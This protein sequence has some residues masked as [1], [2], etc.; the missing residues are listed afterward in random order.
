MGWTESGIYTATLRDMLSNIIAGDVRLVTS[1]LALHNNTDTPDFTLDPATWTNAYE[2][3]DA[4]NWTTGGRLVSAAASG[5]GS[6]APTMAQSSDKKSVV[7]DA[8]DVSVASTTIAAARGLKWQMDALSPKAI[9]CG[10]NFGADYT[11]SAGTF[12]IT[13]SNSPAG[14][15][16]I[17][18][19]PS[20]A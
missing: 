3:T 5:G 7:F 18:C 19:V 17:K 20:G 1:K 6:I 2:V 4:S 10:I 11:T 14:I 9:I 16:V 12:A 8:T 15:F 13:W